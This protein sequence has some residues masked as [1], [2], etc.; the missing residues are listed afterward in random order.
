MNF[1]LASRHQTTKQERTGELN[2]QHNTAANLRVRPAGP[3]PCEGCTSAPQISCGGDCATENTEAQRRVATKGAVLL[4]E[5][6][7]VATQSATPAIKES[8]S[9]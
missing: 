5:K 9:E 2:L 3:P 7:L 1:R 8:D 6:P 4:T